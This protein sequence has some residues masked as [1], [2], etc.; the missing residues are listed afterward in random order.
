[1]VHSN[2]SRS[3]RDILMPLSKRGKVT[4]T[5]VVRRMTREYVYGTILMLR[6]WEQCAD[7]PRHFLRHYAKDSQGNYVG[8]EK[9]ALDAALVFVPSQ[10]SSNDMLQQVQKVAFS[11][12]HDQNGF[13]TA[14]PV[15]VTG[16]YGGG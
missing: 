10:N 11:R 7:A 1:M 3:L 4:Q 5:V 12:E 9:A 14:F 13:R 8:T 6:P 2:H 15:E 16:G